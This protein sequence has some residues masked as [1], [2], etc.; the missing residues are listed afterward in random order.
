MILRFLIIVVML[1]FSYPAY[2]LADILHGQ[3]VKVADGDTITLQDDQ[4]Q[5][6]RIRLAGIDAPEMNQPYGFSSHNNLRSLVARRFV[7]V[8]YEKRD[9]YKRIVGKVLVDGLDV[10]LEQVKAGLAWHYKFYQ[11]EQSKRDR[12][13]YTEHENDAQLNLLGLWADS[14]PMPPWE[15]RRR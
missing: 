14:E 3:V 4:G 6:H 1:T 12:H 10:C 11:R 2:V 15:W 8:E 13:L 7:M 5:K 9:R